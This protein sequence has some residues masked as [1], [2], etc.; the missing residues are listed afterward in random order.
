MAGKRQPAGMLPARGLPRWCHAKNPPRRTLGRV[1]RTIRSLL[2]IP[3][4][5]NT[6]VSRSRHHW[7]ILS[8]RVVDGQS[9]IAFGGVSAPGGAVRV[10]EKGMKVGEW[11]GQEGW[12]GGGKPGSTGRGR[13]GTWCAR[14]PLFGQGKCA[15]SRAADSG[16]RREGMSCSAR[17]AARASGRC[18]V[19]GSAGVRVGR[20]SRHHRRRRTGRRGPCHSEPVASSC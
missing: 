14:F 9:K 19:R 20:A 7:R 11:G 16:R 18:G 13:T 6:R 8:K 12:R 2:I 10:S 5:G 15:P 4:I 1:P 17:R 3:S